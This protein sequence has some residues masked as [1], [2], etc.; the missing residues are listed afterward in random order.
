MWHA[1]AMRTDIPI[2][3]AP[4]GPL[5]LEPGRLLL[6]AIRFLTRIPVP[7]PRFCDGDLRRATPLFGLVGAIVAGCGI[8]TY[9]LASM[10]FDPV[11]AVLLATAVEV[12]VTGAFHEDGLAD[13]A[14]GIWGGWTKEDRLRIMRDSRLGTYG[15]VALVLVLA[16]RVALLAGMDATTFWQ[17]TLAAHVLG[18]AAITVMI[19]LLPPADTGGSG[20]AVSDPASRLGW[21][22]VIGVTGVVLWVTFGAWAWVPVVAAALPIAATRRLYRRRLGGITGD[23][24]GATVMLVHLMTVA[25]AAA[26]TTVQLTR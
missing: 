11:V 21:L 4:A 18:R 24:L 22:T 3:D 15:T 16:L 6:V 13:V 2:T 25:V 5:L 7:E 17:A 23:A 26:S 12:G 19:A 14:D 1:R 20:A 8:A 10:L 9:L